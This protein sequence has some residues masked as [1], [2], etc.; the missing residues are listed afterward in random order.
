WLARFDHAPENRLDPIGQL[1]QR[2]ADTAPQVLAHR[3]AVDLRQTLV[4]AEGSQIGV[5][6]TE[7]DRGRGVD[8]PDLRQ[9]AARLLLALV[10]RFF[11]PLALGNVVDDRDPTTLAA[12]FERLGREREHTQF[13]R[14]PPKHYFN[15]T[16]VIL[17]FQNR[18]HARAIRGIGPESE[19][20]S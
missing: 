16:N 6:E 10:Q 12:K 7:A 1:R 13:A 9:L 11:S 14:F 18:Q 4:D 20:K 2:L 19:V 5:H 15:V 17:L 3:A 8:R